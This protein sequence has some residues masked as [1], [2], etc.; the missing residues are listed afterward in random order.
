M[1]TVWLKKKEEGP[2]KA[3]ASS[4]IDLS[5]DRNIVA[6]FFLGGGGQLRKLVTRA[7]MASLRSVYLSGQPSLTIELSRDRDSVS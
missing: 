6:Y 4:F 1:E 2:T 5:R 7:N 3:T